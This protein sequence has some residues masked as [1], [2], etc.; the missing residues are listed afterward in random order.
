MKTRDQSCGMHVCNATV[1]CDAVIAVLKERNKQKNKNQKYQLAGSS[2]SEGIL[3][4]NCAIHVGYRVMVLVA[5]GAQDG[6]WR[7]RE[8]RGE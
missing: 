7:T 6:D 1:I 8:E 5:D 2:E 3:S 4:V